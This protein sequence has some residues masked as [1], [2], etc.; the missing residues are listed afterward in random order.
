MKSLVWF[1][2]FCLPQHIFWDPEHCID[3]IYHWFI[4]GHSRTARVL[5]A[6]SIPGHIIFLAIISNLK[7]GH[8]STTARFI[9]IYLVAGFIQVSDLSSDL[10]SYCCRT[11]GQN[12]HLKQAMCGKQTSD[13][14]I[15]A[16]EILG[17][18]EK[19]NVWTW[20]G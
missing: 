14:E 6:I 12:K 1:R 20:E 18:C 7:A 10:V 19:F 8:T 3:F 9:C 17:V 16:K 5:L 4:G 15:C 13:Y 2:F 11:C